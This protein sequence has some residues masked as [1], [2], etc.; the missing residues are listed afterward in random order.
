MITV[1]LY[2]MDILICLVADSNKLASIK[3]KSTVCLL[4]VVTG[5]SLSC[6]EKLSVFFLSI[7]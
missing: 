7:G 2:A 6:L 5:A 4:L 1:L 3:G